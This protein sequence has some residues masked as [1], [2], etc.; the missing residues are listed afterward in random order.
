M[1]VNPLTGMPQIQHMN[2]DEVSEDDTQNDQDSDDSL[3]RATQLRLREQRARG[4]PMVL[5]SRTNVTAP[6]R[7][8]HLLEGGPELD[9]IENDP[10]IASSHDNTLT[11]EQLEQLAQDRLAEIEP[12]RTQQA[13]IAI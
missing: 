2:V 1:H 10:P 3:A 11:N 8:E 5:T 12:D 9:D 6:P 7:Q 13:S 4:M